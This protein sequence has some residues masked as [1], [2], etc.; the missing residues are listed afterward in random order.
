MKTFSVPFEKRSHE[1]E[2]LIKVKLILDVNFFTF[3][4]ERVNNDIFAEADV[5]FLILLGMH[6][7]FPSVLL[8]LLTK[9]W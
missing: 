4:D 9:R 6:F 5:I 7:M 3:V 2:A 1:L 8:K